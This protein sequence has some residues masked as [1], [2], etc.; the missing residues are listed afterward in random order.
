MLKEWLVFNKLEDFN[1]LLK[2][3]DDDFTPIKNLC[4][5]NEY[6]E[7]LPTTPSG[8]KYLQHFFIS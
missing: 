1:S 3:T 6:G 4:N 2:Y 7:M 5:V 8:P